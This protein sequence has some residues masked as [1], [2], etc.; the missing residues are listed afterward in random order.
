MGKW[1]QKDRTA[2]EIE[3]SLWGQ[4]TGNKLKTDVALAQIYA[5]AGR[6]NEAMQI[7]DGLEAAKLGDNDYRHEHGR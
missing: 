6:N 4:L 2:H 1:C 7:I 3:N 5:A